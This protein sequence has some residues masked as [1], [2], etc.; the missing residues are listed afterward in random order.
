MGGVQALA[1][2]LVVAIVGFFSSFPIFLAGVTAMGATPAQAS[3]ALM[4]G[5]LAMG[6]AGILLALWKKVPAS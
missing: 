4:A 2:G 6:V 3:S 5:A 1:T